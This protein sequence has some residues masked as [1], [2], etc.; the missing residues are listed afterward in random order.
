MGKRK[1]LSKRMAVYCLLFAVLL[2]GFIGALS[3][4]TYYYNSLGYYKEYIRTVLIGS[5]FF[6]DGEELLDM[7]RSGLIN[8][9]YVNIEKYYDSLIDSSE[10]ESIYV[11]ALDNVSRYRYLMYGLSEET[12]VEGVGYENRN[13]AIEDEIERNV[14]ELYD[15]MIEGTI[16]EGFV[17]NQFE[18]HSILSGGIPVYN[19]SEVV[20]VIGADISMEA[21][22]KDLMDFLKW[23]VAGSAVTVIIFL[24]LFIFIIHKSIIR[25]VLCIGKAATRFI[26]MIMDKKPEEAYEEIKVNTKDEIEHLANELNN[27]MKE[28]VRYIGSIESYSM[29]Q[30]RYDSQMKLA[31]QI[32]DGIIPNQFPAFPERKEFDIYGVLRAEKEVSR[33]FYDFFLVDG[34]HLG[35]VI[36]EVSGEGVPAALFMMMTRTLIKNYAML[37]LEPAKVLTDVNRELCE[38]NEAGMTAGVLFGILDVYNGIFVYANAGEHSMLQKEAEGNTTVVKAEDGFRLGMLGKVPFSQESLRLG[39]GGSLLFYTNGVLKIAELDF[40]KS[41][42]EAAKKNKEVTEALDFLMGEVEARMAE[43]GDVTMVMV[44]VR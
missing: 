42:D 29:M 21:V 31:K 30:E 34:T 3:A 26:H 14:M 39:K 7:S 15:R 32:Q 13:E 9:Y 17:V 28:M 12:R 16:E 25:P 40:C 44:K 8:D 43:N 37:G 10:I 11:L 27:M 5:R 4:V 20:G 33:E 36:A 19:Q 24:C 35:I 1:K 2:S 6:L 22:S 23:L 18:G 38:N 41:A